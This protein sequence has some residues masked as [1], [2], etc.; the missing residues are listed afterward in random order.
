MKKYFYI[1]VL[2]IVIYANGRVN[3]QASTINKDEVIFYNQEE[4]L[5]V[6]QV[7][8]GYLIKY[9]NYVLFKNNNSEIKIDGNLK[10]FDY[11]QSS[12]FLIVEYNNT[13]LL[14]KIVDNKV[15]YQTL[16]E[17]INVNKMIIDNNKLCLFGSSQD[18]S[19]IYEYTLNLEPIKYNKYFETCNIEFY[20]VI[21]YND[22]W[23]VFGLKNGHCENEDIYNVG[24]YNDIKTVIFI[25]DELFNIKSIKYLNLNCEKEIPKVLKIDND[26]IYYIIE[27][28]DN[29]YLYQSNL[30]FTEN[31]LMLKSSVSNE[32]IMLDVNNQFLVFYY[33]DNL[34]M[35]TPTETINIGNYNKVFNYRINNGYLELIYYNKN[36]L[37]K[38]KIDEY[39]IDKL[40]TIEVTYENG[41]I[42]FE[43]DL[44]DLE[45]VEIRSYFSK[46]EVFCNTDFI[47]NVSGKHNVEL[48]IKREN[49][50][51]VKVST[52]VLIKEYVNVIDGGVYCTGHSL[53]F[54]GIATLN[55]IKIN[56][57]HNITEN[58]EYKLDISD[59]LG[60]IKTYRF[61][62]IDNY[63]QRNQENNQFDI[64]GCIGSE[65]E[66][67]IPLE[68]IE[69]MELYVDNQKVEF[70]CVD[71]KLLFKLNPVNNYGVKKYL[72]N[73]IV[74]KDSEYIINKEISVNYLKKLP[75]IDII[76]NNTS[77]P[78][79]SFIIN[80]VDQTLKYFELKLIS[81]NYSN[82]LL[83]CFNQDFILE[84][85][86]FIGGTIEV[87]ACYELGDGII[88][89][90]LLCSING[91]YKSLNNLLNMNTTI[92]GERIKQ[93]D[94]NINMENVS[95]MNN[96][97]IKNQDIVNKYN[98]NKD[99][100]SL[101]ISLSLTSVIVLGFIVYLIIKK[102]RI[103][104]A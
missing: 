78:N 27:T 40:E 55:G 101:I 9:D 52:D 67:T 7:N 65:V 96:L 47:K 11:I 8:D 19:I 20:D 100:T 43:K 93:V 62:V 5:D 83:Y 82:S 23:Y 3:T 6:Y 87:Y 48:L 85:P 2:L 15:T 73:K 102:R 94:L 38:T 77:N 79:L 74:T 49:H 72:I 64:L 84:D 39:H 91:D 33:E 53:K 56:N 12:I 50:E 75:T 4:P 17:N 31:Y 29:V 88:R 58:G 21:K 61:I 42:D 41:N 92:E 14:S 89:K 45:E 54:L 68:N 81:N 70:N 99:F 95:K 22:K 24:N 30:M 28:P 104:K 16:D 26:M 90:E 66:V 86:N 97:I 44:N 76:E 60:N 25:L 18:F 80:D 10:C 69:V 103:K 71:G 36:N 63:Y 46:V 1:L 51:D 13:I 57:G 37:C 32:H 59:N 34:Q 35:K 98:S